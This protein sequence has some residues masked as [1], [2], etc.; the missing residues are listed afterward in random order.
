M[1]QQADEIHPHDSLEHQGRHKTHPIYQTHNLAFL[2]LPLTGEAHQAPSLP[3]PGE[4]VLWR[5]RAEWQAG[6][7]RGTRASLAGTDL[8]RAR[9]FRS[10]TRAKRHLVGRAVLRHILSDMLGCSAAEIR[11]NETLNGQPRL[12]APSPVHDITLHVSFAGIWIIVAVST[13]AMG[14]GAIV[15]GQADAKEKDLSRTTTPR[16][17][18][19]ARQQ[20]SSEYPWQ[21]QQRARLDS[22]ASLSDT[23]AADTRPTWIEHR[24]AALVAQM[25]DGQRC[26]VLDLP[27]PGQICA[28]IATA[29]PVWLIHAY[30]WSRHQ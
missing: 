14:V 26:H 24:G 6:A 1:W 8:A 10:P 23:S 5:C 3:A 11:L 16:L 2:R 21:A 27:M 25:A 7:S 13:T 30:G 12:A 9:F 29:E 15:P 28:A 17:S 20:P 22:L 4:L 19:A 18:T